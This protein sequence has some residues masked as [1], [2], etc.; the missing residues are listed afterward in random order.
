MPIFQE[1]QD[2]AYKIGRQGDTHPYKMFQ[3]LPKYIVYNLIEQFLLMKKNLL[4]FFFWVF[5]YIY[6]QICPLK[7]S[8]F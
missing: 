2:K 1:G 7:L 4:D 5:L 8:C 6:V 3:S